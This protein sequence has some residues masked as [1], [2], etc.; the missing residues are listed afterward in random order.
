MS[1]FVKQVA[2]RANFLFSKSSIASPQCF[3]LYSTR[4]YFFELATQNDLSILPFCK[5][6]RNR[7]ARIHYIKLQKISDFKNHLFR[8]M[9]G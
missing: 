6:L 1:I 4:K 7:M 2:G 9:K 3:R 8:F 5:Y